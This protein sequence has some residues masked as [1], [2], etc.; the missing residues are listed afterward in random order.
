[1]ND[2]MLVGIRESISNLSGNPDRILERK[3]LLSIEPVPEAFSLHE[4]H[5]VVEKPIG[6]S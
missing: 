2:V 3:L 5:D 6:L 4:W 1:M